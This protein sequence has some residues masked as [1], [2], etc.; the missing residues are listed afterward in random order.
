MLQLSL[1]T[2]HK[3]KCRAEGTPRPQVEWYKDGQLLSQSANALFEGFSLRLSDL[4]LRDSGRYMCKAI[5]N[6]G[7]ITFTYTVTVTGK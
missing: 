3:L 5:N 1:G 7:S 6:L 2:N 4:R